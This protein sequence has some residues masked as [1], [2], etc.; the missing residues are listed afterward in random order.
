MV[1]RQDTN[2]KTKQLKTTSHVDKK[3]VQSTEKED[4]KKVQGGRAL[5]RE[6]RIL[7]YH[8]GRTDFRC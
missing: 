3:H 6:E 2:K 4:L 8:K 7:G 1:T 5:V